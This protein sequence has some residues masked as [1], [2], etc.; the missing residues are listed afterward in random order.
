MKPKDFK[1]VYSVLCYFSQML[2][3]KH[4]YFTKGGGT[5][6][7]CGRHRA[8]SLRYEEYIRKDIDR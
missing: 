6:V 8:L 3:R 2:S 1:N 4:R 5:T 7:M